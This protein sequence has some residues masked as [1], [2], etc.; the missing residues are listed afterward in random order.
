MDQKNGLVGNLLNLEY[1]SWPS[2]PQAGR[3]GHGQKTEQ[4]LPKGRA[5]RLEP[6]GGAR[7]FSGAFAFG[8]K[9]LPT[10]EGQPFRTAVRQADFF[11]LEL[12]VTFL[13]REK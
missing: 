8:T 2:L 1:S 6:Q 12:L 13:S 4:R 3:A 7:S 10:H 5:K 11:G 9:A